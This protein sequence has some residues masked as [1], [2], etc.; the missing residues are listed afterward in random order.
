MGRRKISK[1]AREFIDKFENELEEI[2]NKVICISN[3]FE[4]SETEAKLSLVMQHMLKHKIKLRPTA[5][6]ELAG[7]YSEIVYID[8]MKKMYD[9]GILSLLDT[10][11]VKMDDFDKE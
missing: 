2:Y 3:H 6:M 8:C 7:I 11:I 10:F 1:E 4:V 5:I 9:K